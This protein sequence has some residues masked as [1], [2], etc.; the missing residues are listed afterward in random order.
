MNW[1]APGASILISIPV[2]CVSLDL[3][4]YFGM[5]LAP[6]AVGRAVC[7]MR[8]A[9]FIAQFVFPDELWKYAATVCGTFPAGPAISIVSFMLKF[10]LVCLGTAT[11]VAMVP[12]REKS[13]DL[14]QGT[15]QRGAELGS[16]WIFVFIVLVFPTILIGWLITRGP[17]AEYDVLLLYKFLRED[18]FL[19][20]VFV[21]GVIAW[22]AFVELVLLPLLRRCFPRTKWM[23]TK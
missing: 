9:S 3:F 2:L 19:M 5:Q 1:K 21:G 20:G 13:D 11:I 7:L 23:R 8:P 18:I 22:A 6:D 16:N 14:A 15:T 10:S 4:T 17:P 12:L